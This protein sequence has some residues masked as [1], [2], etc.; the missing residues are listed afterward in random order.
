L[1]LF[2]PRC[3]HPQLSFC[4]SH[5]RF[6]LFNHNI[7]ERRFSAS[8]MCL[9]CPWRFPCANKALFPLC[10]SLNPPPLPLALS[11]SAALFPRQ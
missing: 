5:S 6:H 7:I 4:T 11:N 1:N 9:G 3:I 2:P 8:Q 10:L